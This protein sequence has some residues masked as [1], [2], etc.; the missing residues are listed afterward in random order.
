MLPNDLKN[1]DSLDSFKSGIKSCQTKESS[2]RLG[3]RYICRLYKNI[4]IKLTFIPLRLD[5]TEGLN[6]L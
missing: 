5:P 6:T 3:K 4:K 2:C 1:S